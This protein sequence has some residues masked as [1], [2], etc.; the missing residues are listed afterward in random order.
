MKISTLIFII[1]FIIIIYILI[2]NVYFYFYKERKKSYILLSWAFFYY[3]IALILFNP[4][5]VSFIKNLY[6]QRYDSYSKKIIISNKLYA[7]PDNILIKKWSD[8]TIFYFG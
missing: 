6:L 7:I 5:I 8:F 3:L 1:S 4:Y 2:S